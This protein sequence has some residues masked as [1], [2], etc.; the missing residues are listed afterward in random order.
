MMYRMKSVMERQDYLPSAVYNAVHDE[1]FSGLAE[2]EDYQEYGL[3]K[4]HADILYKTNTARDLKELHLELQQEF[5]EAFEDSCDYSIDKWGDK[6]VV[7]FQS[8]VWYWFSEE[9][10]I[11]ITDYIAGIIGCDPSY[12]DNVTE[13]Y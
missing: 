10:N 9:W 6:I 7:H 8:I 13:T 4:Y 2:D 11:P 3:H 5:G 1:D 12:I